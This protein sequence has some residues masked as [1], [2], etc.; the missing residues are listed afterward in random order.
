MTVSIDRTHT[1]A[2]LGEV[3][4]DILQ[5]KEQPM[6]DMKTINGRTYVK[7]HDLANAWHTTT[8]TI[9]ATGKPHQV[10]TKYRKTI[11]GCT[12]CDVDGL[13]Y[14]LNTMKTG[15]DLAVQLKQLVDRFPKDEKHVDDG[16]GPQVET[17]HMKDGHTCTISRC[18]LQRIDYP[19]QEEIQVALDNKQ[20]LWRYKNKRIQ[21][22]AQTLSSFLD[23][24][25]SSLLAVNK[26]QGVPAKFIHREWKRTWV[27]LEGLKKRVENTEHGSV[28]LKTL[29]QI[30]ENLDAYKAAYTRPP[31]VEEPEE[32]ASVS[33][34][35]AK[36]GTKRNPI[37]VCD[38]AIEANKRAVHNTERLNKIDRNEAALENLIFK[39]RDAVSVD[40]GTQSKRLDRIFNDL[41]NLGLHVFGRDYD[42]MPD[43]TLGLFNKLTARV[44]AI[45][46]GDK[47]AAQAMR[48]KHT[49]FDA[50]SQRVSGIVTQADRLDTKTDGLVSRISVLEDTSKWLSWT[51]AGV[52]GLRFLGLMLRM[53]KRK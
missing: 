50:L 40:L 20:V 18:F 14:R 4:A 46:A 33:K 37:D 8:S 6:P 17:I 30:I 25:T 27:D 38:V 3:L 15:S 10:P 49:P 32:S 1:T 31:I 53:L 48:E 51:L 13:R 22:L 47:K 29:K 42:Q 5:G 52:I 16:L 2:R 9:L 23:T 28:L 21:V 11:D 24:R 36:P 35:K 39:Y 12:W 19:S 26:K 43:N 34:P 45:E 44:D 41:R 7:V